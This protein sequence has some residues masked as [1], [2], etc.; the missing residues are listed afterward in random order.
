MDA[1][2]AWL[3]IGAPFLAIVIAVRG[4]GRWPR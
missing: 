3:I 2:V 4:L 1:V